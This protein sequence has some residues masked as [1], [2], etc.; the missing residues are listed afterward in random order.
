M[1]GPQALHLDVCAPAVPGWTLLLSIVQEW[2]S[3]SMLGDGYHGM[4]GFLLAGT[5]THPP[6]FGKGRIHK[7]EIETTATREATQVTPPITLFEESVIHSL[8]ETR[9]IQETARVLEIPVRIVQKIAMMAFGLGRLEVA[10][11]DF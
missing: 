8:E 6:D 11:N 10:L 5:F 4:E 2:A 3:G 9:S 1:L 7:G